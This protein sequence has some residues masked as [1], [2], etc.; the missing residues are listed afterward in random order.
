[1]IRIQDDF[2]NIDRIYQLFTTGPTKLPIV[3][4]ISYSSS[5]PW[6]K[7]RP[8][9]VADYAA[10]YGTSRHFIARSLNG[11]AD[12]LSQKVSSGSKFNVFRKD[13]HI[14]FHLVADLSRCKMGLYYYDQ[15]TNERVLLKTYRI[16]VGRLETSLPSGT[17]T[18]T[19]KYTLGK[20]VAIYKPGT[21]GYYGDQKIEMVNIFG[22]RWIPFDQELEGATVP[23]K[24][25]GLS[26]APWLL[27]SNTGKMEEQKDCVGV[28]ETDGCIRLTTE[29]ME[30]LFSIVI[31]KP[32]II[33]IVRDFRDSKLPGVEVATPKR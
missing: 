20:K 26:G 24:G 13:K 30:E 28:Y 17:L 6:L 32:S 8:A 23:S 19:G 3:E 29:D 1:M 11:K 27:D 7:G 9:W 2:P 21:T 16:G 22:T 10:Y 4:T 33:E 15:D 5:V 18:P 25:Y 12:Y 14:Q 31:T